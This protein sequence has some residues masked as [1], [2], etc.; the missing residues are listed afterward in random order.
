MKLSHPE[1]LLD[2]QDY[3]PVALTTGSR[4]VL[5]AGQASVRASG[6]VTAPD[7]AGQV[8]TSLGNIVTG[9]EGAGGTVDDIARLTIYVVGWTQEMAGDLFDGLARAQASDGYASPLPPITVIGVQALWTPELL[10][11]IEATAV[12]V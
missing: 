3:A 8:H 11:E 2:Q 9:V 12:L 4:L 5:L 1:G 7:L 6:E 10:V